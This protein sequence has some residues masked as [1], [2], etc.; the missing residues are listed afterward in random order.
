MTRRFALNPPGVEDAYL[1]GLQES[2]P[3]WGGHA[4]FA[5]WFRREVGSLPADLLT[6]S[7]GGALVAGM[8]VGYRRWH[9]GDGGAGESVVAILSGA[10]TA[11]AHRRRGCFAELV[12]HARAAGTARGA[13]GLLAF[14][15]GARASG[16]VL[17]G[18][19][20]ES[21]P[22]WRLHARPARAT[23]APA[24]S[25]RPSTPD[26]DALRR[27]FHE[28]RPGGGFVYPTTD[29]FAEQA[30]LL[31]AGARILGASGG[32]WVILHGDRVQAVLHESAPI[33]AGRAAGALAQIAGRRPG[34]VAYTTSRE[35]A[36]VVQEAGFDA[37]EGR[38]FAIAVAGRSTAKLRI[39]E[40]WLQELDRA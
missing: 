38:V 32:H 15:S 8:A 17:E 13:A 9:P 3:G 12:E 23:A 25:P 34:L 37:A 7:H 31:H 4:E 5:W 6:L 40:A 24:P 21:I 28:H 1:R 11:P 14:V 39:G 30:R 33:E 22:S 19:A 26:E 18:A 29:V 16:S 36:D 20:Q 2:F 35:L 10:W 27:W